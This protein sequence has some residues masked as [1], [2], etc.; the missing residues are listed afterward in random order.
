MQEY[1]ARHDHKEK[2]KKQKKADAKAKKADAKVKKADAKAKKAD[3]NAKK[4]DAKAK[5]D[6]AKAKKDNA[7]ATAKSKATK[8]SPPVAERDIDPEE[9]QPK[10][11]FDDFNAAADPDP[12][13]DS[14]GQDAKKQDALCCSVKP[15]LNICALPNGYI[16]SYFLLC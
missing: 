11:L 7:K 5:K 13:D 9:L 3:A 2:S 15:I 4:D 16:K 8:K 12:V 6:D 14:V 1:D 10:D